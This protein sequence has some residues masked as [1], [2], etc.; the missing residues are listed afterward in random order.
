MCGIVGYVGPREATP[1]IVEGLKRLEYRGYDSAGLAVIQGGRIEVRRDVGKLTNL[2]RML[3]EDMVRGNI[4]IGHTR[5]ATHGVPCPRNAHPHVDCRGEVVVI[6]N[7]IVENFLSLRQELMAQGHRFTSETDTETIPHLVEKYLAEGEDLE[8]A[9]RRALGRIK[10]AH[11]VVVMS[12]C[13]PDR[14]VAARLGNA[15]G[16]VVGVGE[17]E[18]FVASDVLAILE[19]TRQVVFLEDRQMAVVTQEG[20][21]FTTLD[22]QPVAKG[23]YEVPWDPISAAKGEYKHFMQ[24]EI[25]EQARSITD[26]IRGRVD[27]EAGQVRL[28]EIN[29]APGEAKA[30]ERMFILACGTSSYAALVGKFMIESVARIPVEVDYGS[31][32][33]YRDPLINERTLV[34]AITQSGETVDTLAAMEEARS[35]GAKLLSIVNVIGSQAARMSEPSGG[36]IYMQAGPEIGVASTKAFSASL[37]DQYL[38]ALH[39]GKLRGLIDAA[40]MKELVEDLAELPNLVG[41]VLGDGGA[42]THDYDALAAKYFK[43]ENFL[44]LGRGINYPIA[45]EGALKL[46]EISYIH[47]EGYPAGEMKHG[48]IAL[49]DEQMPVVA[50]A[51]RDSVYE[52]MVS[53]IE[54]VKA[55]GGIVIALAT[56][57]DQAIAEKADH[58]IYVPPT[59]PLLSPVV[60]VVPLQLLA[61]F[62]AVRRGCDV[63]QPRN[64]AKSVTVE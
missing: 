12:N 27:F 52:K 7:G 22:G 14:F 59:S 56:E 51:G 54:Q 9:V 41:Q 23:I 57:G 37:V 48:P 47:A 38:L 15:G 3:A 62:I 44:Y 31:E 13:Q 17:G 45:L 29:I 58:V 32:F 20:A 6:H 18:M 8:G 19:H 11:A 2:E 25:Y 16:V 21:R 39:L 4:G 42:H 64:L 43:R 63:D 35:K 40:R 46:K 30:I 1:I 53:Q 34:L 36:V 60:N 61:Y 33:R 28:D 50:I 49:I 26:T 10:G 24:K 5:W 55:R